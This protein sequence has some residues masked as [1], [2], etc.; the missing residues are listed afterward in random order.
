MH[1]G[2]KPVK[3]QS[4][5]TACHGRTVS[6]MTMTGH[7]QFFGLF[8]PFFC[9]LPSAMAYSLLC[10]V[11]LHCIYYRPTPTHNI[12]RLHYTTP[13][14]PWIVHVTVNEIT[15]GL[16]PSSIERHQSSV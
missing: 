14:R 12:N 3:T 5:P 1:K 9:F 16:H 4:S 2:P 10:K 11:N 8:L 15:R 6:V 13:S 7:S